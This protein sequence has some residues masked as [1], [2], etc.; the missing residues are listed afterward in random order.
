M[1]A[2]SGDSPF[3][4]DDFEPIAIAPHDGMRLLNSAELAWLREPKLAPR[5][6]DRD[7]Q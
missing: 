2:G 4:L 5:G 1:A 7:A 3:K 6:P